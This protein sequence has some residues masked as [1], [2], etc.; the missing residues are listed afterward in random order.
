[1]EEAIKKGFSILKVISFLLV[2]IAIIVSCGGGD[3]E[4]MIAYIS[5][6]SLRTLGTAKTD[7]G[8]AIAVDAGGN[9][10]IAGATSGS[11]VEGQNNLGGSDVF[12]VK[13]NSSG[14]RQWI[15][16]FGTDSNDSAYGIAVDT[17]GFVYITGSTSGDLGDTKVDGMDA[18]LAK[19]DSSGTQKWIK[20]FGTTGSDGATA[21][22]VDGDGFV[23][24]TG[25]Q[26]GGL[27][28]GEMFVAKYNNG[29]SRLWKTN[30]T[31]K[32]EGTGVA[33]DNAGNVY[34]TGYA[35]AAVPGYPDSYQGGEGDALVMQLNAASGSPRWAHLLGTAS[36][37]LATD[38]SVDGSG[39]VYLTGITY[40]DLAYMGDPHG[41][42]DVFVAKYN[43]SG[44]QLWVK[45]FGTTSSDV[46]NAI[47]ASSGGDV[48]IA[49]Y[50]AGRLGSLTY[51]E[52]D[53]FVTKYD[54]NGNRQGGIEQ[55]GSAASDS[56][57]A[58]AVSGSYVYVTGATSCNPDSEQPEQDMFWLKYN[59]SLVKQ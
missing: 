27:N 3:D 40:G 48:Y 18:F 59:T 50:T 57:E 55:Y 12:V 24:L 28:Q 8:R 25:T 10:Y 44:N 30:L 43:S 41:Q 45:Q 52:N 26:N 42:G 20:Q 6:S 1:M 9:F 36:M 51:G 17:D 58:V 29:G 19:Y 35:T 22:A 21:I 5:C 33:V 15:K 46:G 34:V 49:G 16:Q 53:L 14:T 23:Y 39:N 32:S 37:D 38:A 7:E 11:V 31:V 13:Y 47:A 4:P 56:A 54:T 2:S